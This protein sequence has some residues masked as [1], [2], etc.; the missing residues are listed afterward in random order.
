MN[1]FYR[2]AYKMTSVCNPG[3]PN[4]GILAVFANPES[5]DWWR[6]NPEISGLQKFVKIVLFKC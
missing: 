2:Y 5:R 6:P 4:P 1:I 3:I